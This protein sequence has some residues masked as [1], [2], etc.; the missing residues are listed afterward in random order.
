MDEDLIGRCIDL[1]HDVFPEVQW[2]EFRLRAGFCETSV[3]LDVRLP[4]EDPLMLTMQFRPRETNC[5]LRLP[6]DAL[7]DGNGHGHRQPEHM[8]LDNRVWTDFQGWVARARTVFVDRDRDPLVVQGE[9]EEP[10]PI[11]PLCEGTPR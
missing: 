5:F 6:G 7:L 4:S 1:V 11:P 3:H 8:K 9:G 10:P 2:S